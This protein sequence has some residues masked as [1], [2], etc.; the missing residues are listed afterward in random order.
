MEPGGGGYKPLAPIRGVT[1]NL[2][3]STRDPWPRERDDFDADR[4]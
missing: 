2:T 3:P 1:S 4:L